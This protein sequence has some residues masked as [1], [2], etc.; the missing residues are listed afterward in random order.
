MWG[1]QLQGMRRGAPNIINIIIIINF[2]DPHKHFEI[3]LAMGFLVQTVEQTKEG[4]RVIR[5]LGIP[6]DGKVF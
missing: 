5:F 2:M 1:I 3:A 6:E 4:V